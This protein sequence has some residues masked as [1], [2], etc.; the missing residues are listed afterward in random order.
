MFKKSIVVLMVMLF[1]G[2]LVFANDGKVDIQILIG[3]VLEMNWENTEKLYEQRY[4]F[5]L[6]RKLDDA[7]IVL[8]DEL[9]DAINNDDKEMLDIFCEEFENMDVHSKN[10]IYSEVLTQI[11]EYDIKRAEQYLPGYGYTD[12]A[13]VY[14]LG[15]ELESNFIQAYWKKE[16]RTIEEGKTYRF[17]VKMELATEVGAELGGDAGAGMFKI[18]GEAHFT[19]NGKLEKYAEV[20]MTTNETVQTETMLKYEKRQV[21]FEI[22]KAPKSSPE[23]W[24]LD[25]S[26]Y[27]YKEFPSETEIVLEPGQVFGL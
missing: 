1:L 4:D 6:N 22:W 2:N 24:I 23:S 11:K 21:F 16:K 18:T 8:R 19:V 13:Y 26:C 27:L 15:K 14:K 7:V 10:F 20:N 17:Y 3:D 25:G 9:I 5:E 12:S